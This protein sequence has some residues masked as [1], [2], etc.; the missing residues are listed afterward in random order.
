[1]EGVQ[2]QRT[3]SSQFV[4]VCQ[5]TSVRNARK[6][7]ECHSDSKMHNILLILKFDFIYM[8]RIS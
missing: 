1:M 4:D 5:A 7:S 2:P 8:K 3:T 6:L